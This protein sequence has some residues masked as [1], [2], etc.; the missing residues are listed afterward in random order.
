MM[1]ISRL[2]CLKFTTHGLFTVLSMLA[3]YY[4]KCAIDFQGLANIHTIRQSFLA[5]RSLC[6]TGGDPT[7]Y[8]RLAHDAL[9]SRNL[10]VHSYAYVCLYKCPYLC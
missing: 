5:V 7:G 8:V 4:Y 1:R 3:G 9:A 10:T 6:T 2:S